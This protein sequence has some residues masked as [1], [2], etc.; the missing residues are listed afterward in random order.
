VG[1]HKEIPK[2]DVAGPNPVSRSD[3]PKPCWSSILRIRKAVIAVAGYGT[4]F[5]PATKAVP[6]EMLPIVDRPIVQYLVEEAVESGIED[7]ILVTR[8]GSDAIVNH[9]DHS[10]GLEAHLAEQNNDHYLE[11][12]RSLSK[13]ANIAVIR[14]GRHL[15]YGNGAPLLAAMPFLDK[16]E[17]FAFMFG[18]DLVMSQ[19]PCLKQL[20]DAYETEKTAAAVIAFQEVA[21]A[22]SVRYG[23]AKLKEGKNPPELE[24]IVEKPSP[25]A[26]PSTMAQIGRFVLPW[27]MIEI[28]QNCPLGKDNELYLTDANCILCGEARVLAHAIE[29][30]WYTTGDPL[31]YLI[32]NVQ[33]ALRHPEIGK[34]FADYL[35]T[36]SLPK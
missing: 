33:Y 10:P 13:M 1:F 3:F 15:P 21:R 31:R 16:N 23:M 6:K 34:Q 2:L 8:A 14:Q 4:R 5:L 22:E 19:T 12:I 20:I 26:A 24:S 27:R 25:Q 7:I 32:A 18:D 9:F 28:L 17:P 36:V 11:I 35:R 30:I 29:G